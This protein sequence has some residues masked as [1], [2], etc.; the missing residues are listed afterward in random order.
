MTMKK[1]PNIAVITN[2]YE[3]GFGVKVENGEIVFK[4]IQ[5]EGKKR[6]SALEFI[7]GYKD[8]IVGKVLD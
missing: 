6:M 8:K 3:D 4:T 1:S 5:L 2:I 7:N